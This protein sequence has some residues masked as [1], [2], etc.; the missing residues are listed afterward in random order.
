MDEMIIL[1]I[2][3]MVVAVPGLLLGLALLT[4]KW[5]PTFKSADAGRSRKVIGLG[6]VS[7]DAMMLAVGGVLVLTR[8]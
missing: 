7:L 4:G 3:L 1:G 8:I 6:L 2:S 5:A